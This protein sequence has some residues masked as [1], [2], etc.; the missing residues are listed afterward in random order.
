MNDLQAEVCRMALKKMMAGQ[1][2]NICT[3]DDILKVTGGVPN[4]EDYKTLR[5]LHCVDFK[6]FS[7]RLRM[8]FPSLLRRVLESTSMEVEVRFKA[9]SRPV[10][11][12]N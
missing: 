4:S 9:L 2:F 10:D 6:E 8:E 1:H 7:P 11:L 3:I 5:M 12:L